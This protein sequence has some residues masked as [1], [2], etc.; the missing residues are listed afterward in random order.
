MDSSAYLIWDSNVI[1]ISNTPRYKE[2]KK[3]YSLIKR[4]GMNIADSMKIMSL[5]HIRIN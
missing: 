3:N 4:I 1:V 5:A 2:H